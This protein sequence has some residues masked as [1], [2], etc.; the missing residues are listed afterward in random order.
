[1]ENPQIDQKKL[2][3]ALLRAS[4]GK[5]DP[6]GIRSARQGDPSALLASLG[7]NDRRKITRLLG[8]KKALQKLLSDEQTQKLLR[9]LSG[10]G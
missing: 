6:S 7:E 8:D 4:K 1:M 5:I 2:T 10:N 9:E 3:D